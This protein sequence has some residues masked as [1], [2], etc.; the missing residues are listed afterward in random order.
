MGLWI[1]QE[2]TRVAV[3][4]R[5]LR[6]HGCKY[7]IVGVAWIEE[8]EGDTSGATWWGDATGA[9]Q[10]FEDGARINIRR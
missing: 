7:G 5:G 4:A 8:Y 9:Q 10:A 2:G 1:C 6:P 3:Q